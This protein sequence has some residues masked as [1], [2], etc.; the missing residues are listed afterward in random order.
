[1]C[2]LTPGELV[3]EMAAATGTPQATVTVHDRFLAEA[4]LR[5][6]H[7]RGPS[8]AAK[9]TPR[10]AANLLTAVLGSLEVRDSVDAVKRF[11]ATVGH[12][13]SRKQAPG[14]T[15][16]TV[17]QIPE[18]EQ[19]KSGHSVVDGLEALF[20]AAASGSFRAAIQKVSRTFPFDNLQIDLTNPGVF[21]DISFQGLLGDDR[22]VKHYTQPGAGDPEKRSGIAQTRHCW[23]DVILRVGEALSGPR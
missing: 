2:M 19:L 3:K 21:A 14:G 22:L 7:G 1:M 6:K 4:G 9:M 16:W 15:I 13:G 18:F 11:A 5:S 20:A 8:G 23:G 17:P 10:D 12:R